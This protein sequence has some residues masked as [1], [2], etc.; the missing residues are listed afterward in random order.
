MIVPTVILNSILTCLMCKN[1]GKLALQLMFQI[2][3]HIK[4]DIRTFIQQTFKFWNNFQK[5]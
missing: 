5:M 2:M 4:Y 3:M 1:M